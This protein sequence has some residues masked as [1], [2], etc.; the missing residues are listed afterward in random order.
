MS[1]S[2]SPDGHA[3]LTSLYTDAGV[4]PERVL[5]VDNG[6]AVIDF[7]AAGFGVAI[8]PSSFRERL[9][10]AVTFT[11]L[12]ARPSTVDFFFAWREGND[13]PVLRAFL[14]LVRA[15]ARRRVPVVA[16]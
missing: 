7:V 12:Q 3:L 1:A 9:G 6:Q 10:S 14:D 15:E 11:S 2:V 8:V 16:V 5:Q 4:P 13:V